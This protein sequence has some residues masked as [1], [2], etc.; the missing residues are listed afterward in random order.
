MRLYSVGKLIL[1]FVTVSVVLQFSSCGKED[2]EPVVTADEGIYINEIYA[3]GD[4]WIELYNSNTSSRDVGGYL[5][6]DDPANKYPLP[7]GTVIPANGYLVLFCNDL[8]Q[9]LN[10]S[11]KL[12]SSGETVYLENKSNKLIDKVTFPALGNNQSY[13]RYP[14]GSQ[15]FAISGNTTQGLENTNAPAI[16]NVT[17]SPL[18]PTKA[19]NVTVRVELLSTTG[20][21]GVKVYY[22]FNNGSFTSLNT[23]LSAGLYSATIPAT[24]ALGEMEYYVEA[25]NSNGSSFRPRTAPE[26]TYSYLLNEDA[27]P[28][29]VINEF[30]ALNTSCCPDKS[31]GT[32][33]FDDWIEIY[34]RGD[35][36]VELKGFYLSDDVSNPFNSRIP[37]ESSLKIPKG[38]YVIIWADGQREQGDNHVDFRLNQSGEAVGLYYKDGRKIDEYTYGTQSENVSTGRLPNGTGSFQPLSTPSPG[39]ANQ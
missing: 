35:V 16:V 30:M 20:V 2:K 8:G 1:F 18:I 38:G 28:D 4:D 27:L 32:D 7:A 25:Q 34:N 14:D 36:D 6:Y 19:D 17:R 22:R 37:L 29:L 3:S 39:A 12:T 5:I 11:F 26:R 9:G 21:T 24:N 23:T 31:G 10:T 15:N 33:E 13:G